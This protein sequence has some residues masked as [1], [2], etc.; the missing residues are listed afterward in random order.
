MCCK[1]KVA[2]KSYIVQYIYYVYLYLVSPSTPRHWDFL[3][4]YYTGLGICPFEY[5]TDIYSFFLFDIPSFLLKTIFICYHIKQQSL[6]LFLLDLLYD[7]LIFVVV[8]KLDFEIA[9]D[10]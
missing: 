9:N 8:V 7:T 10:K 4:Q 5:N 6:F 3:L 2:L 1:C